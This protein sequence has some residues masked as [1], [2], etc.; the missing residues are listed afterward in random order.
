MQG[1]TA[2]VL[3]EATV[4]VSRGQRHQQQASCVR[5]G[6]AECGPWITVLLYSKRFGGLQFSFIACTPDGP[7][8]PVSLAAALAS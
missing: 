7:G 4:R 1:G 3:R 8:A 2:A 6:T 5:Q